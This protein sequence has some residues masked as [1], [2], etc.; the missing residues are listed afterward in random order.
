V[1]GAPS[2]VTCQV[3]SR[4]DSGRL[5]QGSSWPRSRRSDAVVKA[6]KRRGAKR[7]RTREAFDAVSVITMRRFRRSRWVK[8]ARRPYAAI[9]LRDQLARG[10][11]ARLTSPR[12]SS[13]AVR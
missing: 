8:Y 1:R 5:E 4:P 2:R 10:P 13:S 7:R 12:I 3:H 11:S 6:A 9:L